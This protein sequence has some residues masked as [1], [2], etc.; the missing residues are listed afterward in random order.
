[1]LLKPEAE[2]E[3]EPAQ[4]IEIVAN[5][6]LADF[7]VRLM[8]AQERVLPSDDEMLSDANGTVVTIQPLSPLK[9]A[10]SLILLMDGQLGSEI[11]NARGDYYE[12]FRA[13]L[14][15]RGEPEKP[16][17]KPPK[18]N[19]KAPKKKTKKRPI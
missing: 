14:K 5:Q 8:D 10:N 15:V 7:R 11:S 9:A 1:L 17:P 19:P 18:K 16:A 4:K 2:F 12:A 6:K 3:M 13:T